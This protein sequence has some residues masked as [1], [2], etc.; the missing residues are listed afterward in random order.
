MIVQELIQKLQALRNDLV[1]IFVADLKMDDPETDD[2]RSFEVISV[3]EGEN[4]EC[5][6][7]GSELD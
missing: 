7:G 1:V 6:L 5:W 4:N 3:E 2:Q